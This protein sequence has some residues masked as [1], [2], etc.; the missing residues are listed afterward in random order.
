MYTDMLGK[1][2]NF[3]PEDDC[4]D[5][6]TGR[7]IGFNP[8]FGDGELLVYVTSSDRGHSADYYEELLDEGWLID[9]MTEESFEMLRRDLRFWYIPV[10]LFIGL[11][12]KEISSIETSVDESGKIIITKL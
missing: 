1:Y 5:I 11:L 8:D 2:C 3:Y 4:D 10:D 12:E 9:L 6:E 7:I